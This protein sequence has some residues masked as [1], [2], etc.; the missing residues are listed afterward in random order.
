MWAPDGSTL[1]YRSQNSMMAVPVTSGMTFRAG[2][3]QE[4]FPD[5]SAAGEFPARAWDIHPDG[6]RFLVKQSIGT[7]SRLVVVV[8]WLNEVRAR[9]GGD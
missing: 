4:L 6:E 1:Y 3:P 2:D 7:N 9:F 8:N 5:V